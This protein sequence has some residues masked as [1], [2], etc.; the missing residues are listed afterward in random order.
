MRQRQS[1]TQALLGETL[2]A[3]YD[4]TLTA[5]LPRRWVELIHEL[6][7]REATERERKRAREDRQRR[8]WRKQ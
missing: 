1:E 5:P 2:T 4:D 6:N 8:D 3:L 7:A